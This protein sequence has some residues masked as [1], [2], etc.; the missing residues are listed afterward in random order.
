MIKYITIEDLSSSTDVTISSTP[1][2][3][4]YVYINKTINAYPIEIQ[5]NGSQVF[6]IPGGAQEGNIYPFNYVRFNTDLHAIMNANATGNVTF[7]IKPTQS[8]GAGITV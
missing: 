4:A 8:F 6:Y 3:L 2:E 1:C 7:V 5:D